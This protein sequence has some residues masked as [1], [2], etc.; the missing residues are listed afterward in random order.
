MMLIA[1]VLW[2]SFPHDRGTVARGATTREV[3]ARLRTIG[4]ERRA[5]LAPRDD[6]E[7]ARYRCEHC[8]WGTCIVV[9]REVKP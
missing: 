1:T 4:I 2:N 3:L 6:D 9:V 7:E 8:G 5:T